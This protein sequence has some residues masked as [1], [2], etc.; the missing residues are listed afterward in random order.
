MVRSAASQEETL[1]FLQRLEP[2]QFVDVVDEADTFSET[3]ARQAAMVTVERMLREV[4]IH[5]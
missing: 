1:R 2:L 5:R 3:K 4:N